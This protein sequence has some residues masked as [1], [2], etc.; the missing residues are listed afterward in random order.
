[1]SLPG[2][3][4]D[5]PAVVVSTA[6]CPNRLSGVRSISSTSLP[7]MA[8]PSRLDNLAL[9][10]WTCNLKKGPNLS[11]VDPMTGQVAALFN[12]RDD[13]WAEHFSPMIDALKPRSDAGWTGYCSGTRAE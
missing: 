11:G 6:V 4:A 1:V 8:G 9:A 12:P 10:C 2:T 3:S 5:A 7:G 13:E